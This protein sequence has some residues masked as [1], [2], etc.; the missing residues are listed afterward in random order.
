MDSIF[1]T[2]DLLDLCR[3]HEKWRFYRG[4]EEGDMNAEQLSTTSASAPSPLSIG[5]WT[6]SALSRGLLLGIVVKVGDPTSW[7]RFPAT[8]RVSIR[9]LVSCCP[10]TGGERSW[11]EPGNVPSP[12]T[13]WRGGL[14][15]L[16]LFGP[17]EGQQDTARCT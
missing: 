5:G 16:G 11:L 12:F 8:S 10:P 14:L 13:Y 4:E 1:H 3:Y 7:Q 17:V 6:L 15:S 9:C 2:G